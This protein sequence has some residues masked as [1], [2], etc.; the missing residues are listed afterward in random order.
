MG[1]VGQVDLGKRGVQMSV[2]LLDPASC[3]EA[4]VTVHA[5]NAVCHRFEG[6]GV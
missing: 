2:L 6:V 4:D 5:L 3:E 1:N